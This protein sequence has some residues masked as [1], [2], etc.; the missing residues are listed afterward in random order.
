VVYYLRHSRF[1]LSLQAIRDDAY[2]AAM[3]G[4]NVVRY[5]SAAWLIAAALA[6]MAGAVFGWATSVFYP[7]AVFD[8]SISVFAIVFALFG[9]TGSLW[10]PTIGAVLLYALYSAIGISNPQF[11]ELIYGLVIILLVLF[12]PRGL[13]GLGRSLVQRVRGAS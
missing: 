12:V 8:A 13:A 2:S 3:A 6:G 1:G 9:G 10:G 11:F 7:T 4:V 5:R